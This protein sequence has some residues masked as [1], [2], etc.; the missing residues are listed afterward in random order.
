MAYHLVKMGELTVKTE[1]I[2]IIKSERNGG[3]QNPE[4]NNI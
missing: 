2:Y 3:A 4:M 1:Y